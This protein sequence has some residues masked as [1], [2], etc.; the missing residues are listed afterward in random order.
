MEH[1]GK[2]QEANEALKMVLFSLQC[3]ARVGIHEHVG[4]GFHRH[5]VD[6]FWHGQFFLKNSYFLIL[7]EMETSLKYYFVHLFLS[8][9]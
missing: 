1:T 4:C 3:L 8:Q 9:S 2:F 5:S 6:K 7:I